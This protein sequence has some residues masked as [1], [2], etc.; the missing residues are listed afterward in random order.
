MKQNEHVDGHLVHIGLRKMKSVFAIFVGFL[1]WQLI[2]LIV[3]GLE[4]HPI[5]I[6]LYG[7]L[8]IRETSEKTINMGMNRL[9]TTFVALGVGLPILF[10]TVFVKGFIETQWLLIAVE[11]TMILLGSLVVLCVAEL[12]GCKTLCGLAA[13]IFI[14]L[15]VSHSDREP[16]TYSILRSSQTIIGISI[17][18]L[19]NVKL[20]PYPR[21]PKKERKSKRQK[22]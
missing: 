17:A 22:N 10:F 3:P 2:R 12:A 4:V 20:F 15:L 11:L 14:I 21:P 16:L 8:E 7:M 13:A 18:W 19:I 5:Y 1:V 6:Y 9:K